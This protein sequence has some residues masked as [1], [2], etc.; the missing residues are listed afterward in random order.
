MSTISRM[1]SYEF[2]GVKQLRRL[3]DAV[4]AVASELSLPIVLRRITETAAEL[5]DARYAALGV[6]DPTRTRLSEFITVGIDEGDVARIGHL[7][8]GHGILG[9]LIVKPK[10]LRLPDLR[11]HPTA[12]DF[13][14]TT[15]R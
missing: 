2:A 15:R 11:M 4:M 8:E 12:T 3:L 5:V 13:P 9:L 10:P 6:L 14:R 1:G 7:P